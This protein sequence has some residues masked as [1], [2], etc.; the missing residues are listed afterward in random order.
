MKLC[1]VRHAEADYELEKESGEFPGVPLT[2]KGFSQA[3]DLANRLKNESFDGIYCSDMLRT[4][5]TLSPS[6]RHLPTQPVYDSRLREISDAAVGGHND[7][8]YREPLKDQ[9]E[10]M[11]S[12]L[13]HI[14]TLKGSILIVCHYG[15]I[16]YLTEKLGKL[17]DSPEY[18]KPYILSL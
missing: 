17:A 5:Q 18:V 2:S 14:K 9:I 12:F 6:L 7:N 8:W 10:R 4:M 1:F 16:R 15:V 3:E 11:E 13:K